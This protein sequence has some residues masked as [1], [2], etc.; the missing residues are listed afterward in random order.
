MADNLKA[1]ALKGDAGAACRLAL[2]YQKCNLAQQQISH[3][4]DVTST[5][6]DESDGVPEIALPLDKA[7]F[8]PTWPIAK[9][10]KRSMLQKFPGCGGGLPKMET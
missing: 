3:A 1:R 9:A 2:E 8:T 10:L 4:D 7:K 6:Q 5:S